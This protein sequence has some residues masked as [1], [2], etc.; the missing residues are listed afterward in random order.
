[1]IKQIK[2]SAAII[3]FINAI[4]I[5]LSYFKIISDS[6]FNSLIFA[7]LISIINYIIFLFLFYKSLK[8]ENKKFIKINLGGMAFRIILVL[9][10]IFLTL[11]FLKVDKYEFIFALLIWY[12]LLMI[13][14]INII[15]LEK[16]VKNSLK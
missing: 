14:E 11:K 1:M 9:A 16:T 7:C 8:E 4:I 6:Q 5:L 15:R 3:I 12:I 10:L 2:L 13:F